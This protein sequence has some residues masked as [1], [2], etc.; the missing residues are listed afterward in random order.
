[1]SQV[2]QLPGTVPELVIIILAR[3][4]GVLVKDSGSGIRHTSVQ[5]QVVLGTR[6]QR[7]DPFSLS[8]SFLIQK[9]GYE[10]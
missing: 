10:N 8:L 7:N 2:I 5:I 4:C 6:P 9:M 3:A 1:M